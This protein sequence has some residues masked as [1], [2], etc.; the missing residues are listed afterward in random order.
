M[1]VLRHN[2]L[3]LMFRNKSS[4]L[5]SV[6]EQHPNLCEFCLNQWFF[7]CLFVLEI[8]RHFKIKKKLPSWSW[9]V[10]LGWGLGYFCEHFLLNEAS[11]RIN[12]PTIPRICTGLLGRGGGHGTGRGNHVYVHRLDM[13]RPGASQE[14]SKFL[15]SLSLSLER[16]EEVCLWYKAHSWLVTIAIVQGLYNSSKL[17]S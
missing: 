6:Y 16:L 1:P 7:F 11:G 8:T 4:A 10:F 2:A 13:L 9:F 5:L 15:W 17:A 3:S 12:L 14:F